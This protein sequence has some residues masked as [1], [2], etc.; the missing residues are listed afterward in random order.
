[1]R[2]RRIAALNQAAPRAFVELHP[3]A[4]TELSIVD[5]QTVRVTTRRGSVTAPARVVAT[6]RPDTLFMPFHWSGAARANTLT[7]DQLDPI[8]KMP[9]FKVC[10]AR[11][12]R[13]V[14]AAR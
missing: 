10:A 13:L 11:I 7:L 2:P 12:D 4:A 14:E 1:M 3:D 6:I 5:G 8:S 9:A